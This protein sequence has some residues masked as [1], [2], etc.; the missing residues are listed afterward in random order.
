LHKSS[1]NA[2]VR[3]NGVTTY[4]GRYGSKESKEACRKFIATLTSNGDV[5]TP[6]DPACKVA[7]FIGEAVLRYLAYAAKYHVSDGIPTGEHTTIRCALDPFVVRFA[8]RPITDFKPA[9][10]EKLQE[11]VIALGRSRR[12]INKSCNIVRRFFKW[13]VR[14]GLVESSAFGAL[15]AVEGLKRGRFEA[16]ELDPVE[17]VS[18]KVYE[19]TLL[20]VSE[21]VADVLR[22]M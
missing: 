15:Q 13:C 19:A 17:P 21:L 18:D 1:G 2:K 12:Y 10:L 6:A 8:E 4:L 11:D 16:R 9:D 7:A 20:H 14:K 22:V 3:Y 5:A